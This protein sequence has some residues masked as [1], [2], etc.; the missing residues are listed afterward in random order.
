MSRLSLLEWAALLVFGWTLVTRL[1]IAHQYPI[2]AWSDSFHH[3]L[4]TQLT[5][6][7]GQLPHSLEPT[8]AIP[9]A[10]Y[11]LGLHG[12]AA[13]IVWL[14][15]ASPHVA[16]Q[17]SAQ[18]LNG[19]SGLGV[20]LILTL[21]T[22]HRAGTSSVRT[23]S[24]GALVGAATVGLFCHMP[25]YYVNWGRFTQIASQSI[26]LIAWFLVVEGLRLWSDTT[27]KSGDDKRIGKQIAWRPLIGIGLAAAILTASI[28][29]LHFRVAALYVLL[30]LIIVPYGLWQSY[31]KGAFWRGLACV[32]IVGGVAFFLALPA[33]WS[34]IETYIAFRQV[35]PIVS[36]PEIRKQAS[37]RYYE[38]PLATIPVLVA[39]SWLLVAAA[40]ATLI[41][42]AR[43][44]KLAVITFLWT[45]LLIGL[46][47]TYRLGIPM[48]NVTNLGMILIMLYIPIG[49]VIG[50]ALYELWTLL[51][52]RLPQSNALASLSSPPQAGEVPSP[53]KRPLSLSGYQ[54]LIGL[55]V[56]LLLAG[57]GL[58][59]WYRIQEI[60]VPRF[61]V[62]A[63]DLAAMAW[64][65]EHTDLDETFAV[66]AEFWRP[67]AVHGE[68]GG[69][70]IPYFTQR[71][72][73]AA[74]MLMFL[75]A[76]DEWIRMVEGAK[77]VLAYEE[78]LS[79]QQLR[80]SGVDY[81]YIGSPSVNRGMGLDPAAI[82]E[83]EQVEVAFQQNGVWI[84]RLLN[85]AP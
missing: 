61:L 35:D 69:Y 72:T 76:R 36:D 44:N 32:G 71:Q 73:T 1:W 4:I 23:G 17:W 40:L 54:W 81:I 63:D 65:R 27:D 13:C 31:N 67:A 84:F 16:L 83:S 39:R 19:L 46:G 49:L 58:T 18:A 56:V 75:A 25:A 43:R 21:Y 53:R 22:R 70:W 11:H 41:G 29:L 48:L 24:A 62:T 64:I 3:T 26:L 10:M 57:S 68:D 85:N 47:N 5:A 77:N 15:Q 60:E 59:G 78:S 28:F 45:L 37:S 79:V 34:A 6:E 42:L 80:A 12:I 82:A 66:N 2:P 8:F 20:Y 52:S 33:L 38:F 30:L 51:A 55:Y 9:L 74:P 14:A 50:V 7:G